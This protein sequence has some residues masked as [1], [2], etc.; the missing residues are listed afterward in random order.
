MSGKRSISDNESEDEFV[1]RKITKNGEDDREDNDDNVK[2]ITKNKRRLA[3]EDIY[4]KQLPSSECYE[5]SY[6]HKENIIHVISAAKTDFIITGKLIK[7][8]F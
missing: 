5:K 4:L 7:F 8:E 2:S 3:F 6:M 1:E